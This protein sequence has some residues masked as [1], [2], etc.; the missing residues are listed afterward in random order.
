MA[1]SSKSESYIPGPSENRSEVNA[2]T[3][4]ISLKTVNLRLM[5][6]K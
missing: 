3:V 6:K 4:E 5:N 2:S 1:R